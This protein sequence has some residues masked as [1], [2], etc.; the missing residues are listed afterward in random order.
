M[1]VKHGIQ[2][3]ILSELK[4]LASELGKVPTR[5]EFL[6]FSKHSRHSI[7]K[8][9]GSFSAAILAA[10]MGGCAAE[11]REQRAAKKRKQEIKG[12]FNTDIVEHIKSQIERKPISIKVPG[13]KSILVIGDTHFPF[14]CHD[15]LALIF[16]WCE[17][18]QP[19]YVVQVGDLYDMFAHSKFPRTHLTFNPR[20]EIEHGFFM[21]KEMWSRIKKLCPHARCY[22]MRGNHDA[23]PL[24]RILECY[25][26]GE[27][28][29][30]IEKYFEF[31][32]VVNHA[33][34]REE[35]VI[36]NIIFH[37]GYL[38]K[39]GAHADYNMNNTV[40]GHTHK[41]GV[42]YRNT[43]NGV[44]WELNA[45]YCGDP[46]SKALS[47]MPQKITKSTKGFGFIDALGP[48]FIA[49]ECA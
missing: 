5:D 39:L 6:N 26:E 8:A 49:A 27:V 10:G 24:K 2:H 25:P 32:D 15:T 29:F 48:R 40:V 33:D 47:Y 31:K 36:E 22:Q 11:T 14:V 37:H 42:V 4:S 3:S 30:S 12:I 18:M 1:S 28:F 7:A 9:F 20:D 41:G 23:R 16:Y 34:Y 21:A 38:T 13:T 45:G 19:D 44:I 46:T 17:I 35:L 43:P